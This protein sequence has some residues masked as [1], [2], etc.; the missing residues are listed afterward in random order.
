MSCHVAAV[1]ARRG[2]LVLAEG[3]SWIARCSGLAHD[4]RQNRWRASTSAVSTLRAPRAG[5]KTSITP[6][7][8]ERL[9]NSTTSVDLRLEQQS[10]AT[11]LVAI[12]DAWLRL[13][14]A[15]LLSRVG[16][17]VLTASNGPAAMR[18]AR[19]HR[20]DIIILSPA[21]PELSGRPLLS[22]LREE[23]S[24]RSTP[25]V[26]AGAADWVH[27]ERCLGPE[28]C[29]SFVSMCRARPGSGSC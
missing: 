22:A 3:E 19:A 1:V 20:C 24:T 5:N 16:Y 8:Q 9:A 4:G 23:P 6:S 13:H 10:R 29:G 21:L 12:H 14:L 18:Q 17:E 27:S 7:G 25:I 28:C 26:V 2:H 11:I 15:D